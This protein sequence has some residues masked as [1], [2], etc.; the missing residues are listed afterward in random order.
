MIRTI[1]VVILIAIFL[2]LT[3]PIRF[4]LSKVAKNSPKAE[5]F[6]L[7][8]AQACFRA[9]LVLSGTKVT[10]SGREH[11]PEY[12]PVLYVSNHRGFFDIVVGYPQV[13]GLCGFIAKKELRKVP[14]LSAYMEDLHC[15]FLDRENPREGLKT[16]LEAIELVKA[17]HSMWICPEGTRSKTPEMLPFQEGSL[18]IATKSG[19]P[20]IP[21]AITGTDDVLE[22]HFPFIKSTKVTITFGHPIYV[23]ELTREQQKTLGKFAQNEVQKLLDQAKGL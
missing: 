9:V 7:K 15:L 5:A 14:L 3:T 8:M 22:K 21:V 1:F 23:D 2:I 16:I 6:Y 19:C 11:I 10:V 13:K 12:R 18:K 17:G 20:I 4:I